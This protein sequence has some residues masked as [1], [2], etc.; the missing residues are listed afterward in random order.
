MPESVLA[1]AAEG[2]REINGSGMSVLEVSHRGKDYEAIHFATHDA[3]L[4]LLGLS[5]DEYSLMFIQGGASMQFAMLPMNLLTDGRTADY[6]NA[7]EWG[8]KAISE[9]KKV[10]KGTINE[11]A[12]S[13]DAKFSYIPKTFSPTPGAT[14]FHVTTNNTIEGTE[15]FDLPKVDAPLVADMSSDFLAIQRDH[16]KMDMIYAGSQKNAGPA[17]VTIVAA[18]KSF[19]AQA[20]GK[21]PAILDYATY[22]EKDSLYNTPPAFAIYCVGLVA[23]W[24]DS[25]GGLAGIEANNREKAGVIYKA[26]DD[27]SG[28]FD[29]AVT[30]KADRSLMN[31]TFRLQPKYAELEKEF[32]TQAS[33]RKMDGLKG[34]RAVGGFRASVYNAFPLEGAKALA[35]FMREFAAAKGKGG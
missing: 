9:A 10:G 24:I 33:A 7:G 13:A 11:V 21:V 17:G 22:S 2:V 6:V 1:E 26:L 14:Y 15:L 20:T 18:R 23:K 29:A 30:D 5:A 25:Q 4:R 8:T 35:S 34:H 31:I 16:H 12:S 32:L 3:L 19:L 28:F 27:L